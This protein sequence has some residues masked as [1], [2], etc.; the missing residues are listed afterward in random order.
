MTPI[1]LLTPADLEAY[2][3]LRLLGLKENP[4]AFASS[5]ERESVQD[6][7]FFAKRIVAN[8][9]QWSCGAF[10]DGRLVGVVSF[11]R[12]GGDK[13]RHRG[14]LWGMYLHPDWRGQGIGRQLMIDMLTRT[15]ALD[16]LRAVRLG[17]TDGNAAAEKLYESLG[18]ERYGS[19]PEVLC[20][21]GRYYGEHYL[22]RT[23][24]SNR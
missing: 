20:V 7:D 9:D 3:E 24:G 19:E 2:C 5:Y 17:V 14:A 1:R 11:V 12:D 18:F 21:D 22:S 15:D 10:D 8:D 23:T 4:T 16:G 13:M 6:S